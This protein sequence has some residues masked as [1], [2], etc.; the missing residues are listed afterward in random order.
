V[1]AIERGARPAL[2]APR[3]HHRRVDSTNE[4]A[5]RLARDGAPHGT[6]VTASEQTAGRGR[7]GR[8]WSAPAGSAVLASVVVRDLE[9]GDALLP[10]AAAVAV[11]EACEA[12]APAACR[13]K[14]PN[15]VWIERRKVAGVLVEG[16]PQDGWAVVG[17]GINVSTA[18]RDFPAELRETA[19]SLGL[20]AARDGADESAP[21]PL[22]V[23]AVLASLV[24]ALDAWL[25][26]PPARILA[27]WRE[28]D[29][30]LGEDVAWDA[31]EGTAAGIDDGGAL[32]VD[33]EAGRVALE[34]GEVHL[35]SLRPADA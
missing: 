14:W 35:G 24:A 1:S 5:K 15:D 22:T 10:L 6:L 20:A 8:S 4:R 29:A 31:G 25:W 34:A 28:R 16:R 7:Q 26:Q 12:S 13:I 33:T 19:T 32:I 18:R 11:C 9:P 3:V 30:L 17:I 23:E 27:A 21:G 2:G